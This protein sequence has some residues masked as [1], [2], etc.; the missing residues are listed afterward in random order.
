MPIINRTMNT[1]LSF[2]YVALLALSAFASSAARA[3]DAPASAS[4]AVTTYM[5]KYDQTPIVIGANAKLHKDFKIQ[6]RTWLMREIGGPFLVR[7]ARW[8]EQAKDTE[9]FIKSAYGP[10]NNDNIED[11][12]NSSET[13]ALADNFFKTQYDLGQ[14][15]IAAGVDDPVLLWLTEAAGHR[16]N[17]EWRPAEKLL[18]KAREHAALAEYSPLV[19]EC[20]LSEFIRIR[21]QA[22]A[23]VFEKE[24]LA[25]EWGE[26]LLAVVSDARLFKPDEDRILL[27][28]A[29]RIIKNRDAFKKHHDKVLALCDHAGFSPWLKA[30]LRGHY[31][32]RTAWNFRGNEFAGKVKEEGWKGF[33]EHLIKAR[34]AL[35]EAW[36][37]KPEYPESASEMIAVVM[38]GGG[39]EKDTLQLWF[40]RAVAAEFD[41][42]PA[43]SAMKWALRPRWGGSEGQMAAFALACA[44]TRRFDTLVPNT[45][46]HVMNDMV[47]EASD[48][49]PVYRNKLIRPVMLEVSEGYLHEPSRLN[50]QAMRQSYLAFNAWLVDDLDQAAKA[51][52]NVGPK[53]PSSV[54]KSMIHHKTSEVIVRGEIDLHAHRM[55]DTW[56]QLEAAT[57]AKYNASIPDLVLKIKKAY[58]T[59]PMPE[60]VNGRLFGFEFED[61]LKKGDWVKLVVDADLAHWKKLAGN[62][63]AENGVLVNHGDDHDGLILYSG[64]V[65]DNFEMRGSYEV[66]SRAN[67]CQGL[68]VVVNYG[69]DEDD[70]RRNISCA[71]WRQGT[72]APLASILS[73]LNLTSAES[74]KIGKVPAKYD[75]HITVH[76]GLITYELNGKELFKNYKPEMKDKDA[77][78]ISF[79]A[80]GQI[81][82]NN[83][84]F[85]QLNTTRISGVEVRRLEAAK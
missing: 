38:G 63:S 8:P 24:K 21:T 85:C 44:R 79:L 83:G 72:S 17:H 53:M 31:E 39:E 78:P 66:Q 25:V 2:T 61:Q 28:F 10:Q 11:A 14:K 73:R 50:E 30:M 22:N 20:I 52:K 43:Y 51:M 15:L 69:Y 29:V 59:D 27:E 36:K 70:S 75:F 41:Y 55:L 40:A 42:L 56:R 81:G 13:K 76:D 23:T 9:R 64:S 37:L 12:E 84:R 54:I 19:K 71:T 18:K 35:A 65:G 46:F 5:E 3:A 1:H 57:K 4:D 45:F 82:F 16:L 26:A 68:G 34:E 49:G 33:E 80:D 6:W 74:I 62:W 32:V 48:W 7:C 60:L 67:C 77:A 47:E 58:G